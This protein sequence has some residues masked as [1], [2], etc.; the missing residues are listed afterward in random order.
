MARITRAVAVAA[1]AVFAALVG[2]MHAAEGRDAADNT[3]SEVVELIRDRCFRQGFKVYDPKPGAIVVRRVLQWG[4][5]DEQPVWGLAQWSSRHT[6]EDVSPEVLPSGSVRIAD[7]AKTVVV[8]QPGSAEADL[9]MGVDSR[10]EWGE[11]HR[12]KG[13]PWPHLLVE[14]RFSNLCPPLVELNELRFRVE[15]R[16]NRAK[17]FETP[18][19]NPSYHAAQ[20]LIFFTVQNRN[21]DSAGYGDFVWL[22][23]PIYDDRDRTGKTIIPGDSLGKLIYTPARSSYTNTP[24]STGVWIVFEAD[25]LPLA[26]E[27]LDEAWA[28]GFVKDSRDLSDYRLG[29]INMGWELTGINNVEMQVRNISLKAVPKAR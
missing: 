29:G 11:R 15:A 8:G 13:E 21:R 19:Y 12:R 24:V 22:G 5:A 6:L 3:S 4:K 17:R 1:A 27:A 2:S 14:Q 16:L 9:V 10:Q 28:R 18:Q 26:S 23:V 25:L 20:F 7:A